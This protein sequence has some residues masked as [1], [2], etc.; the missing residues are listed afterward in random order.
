[1]FLNF[2][3]IID[4]LNIS[5]NTKNGFLI[6]LILDTFKSEFIIIKV[7]KCFIIIKT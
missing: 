4:F 3:I 6:N 2:L 1:M 7:I 5:F